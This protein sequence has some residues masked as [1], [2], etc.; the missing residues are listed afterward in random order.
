M[1]K[2]YSLEKEVICL[3]LYQYNEVSFLKDEDFELYSEYWQAIK[4]TKGDLIKI[5]KFH[6]ELL[7]FEN[8][9]MFSQ[10]IARKI[11][12]KHLED[13]FKRLLNKT[14]TWYSINMKSSSEAFILSEI[15]AESKDMELSSLIS[16]LP[17]YFDNVG[18]DSSKINKWAKYCKERLNEFKEHGTKGIY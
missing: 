3:G 6:P 16:C 5:L 15:I 1:K 18:I 17:E 7:K 13:R 4:T 10:T 9:S 8:K 2:E 12:F 11:A 14:Y